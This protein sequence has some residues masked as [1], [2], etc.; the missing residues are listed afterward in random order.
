V[1]LV[2]SGV[3]V[4]AAQTEP[5]HSR[6][7]QQSELWLHGPAAAV[8][9]QVLDVGSQVRPAQQSEVVEQPSPLPAQLHVPVG[10]H[11]I[12]AQHWPSS[13]Q[14]WPIT[15]QAHVPALHRPEQQS[16]AALQALPFAVHVA[17]GSG[18][19][20][21]KHVS[22]V[23]SQSSS[24][25]QSSSVAQVLPMPAQAGV[26]RP[27]LQ[28][29]EQQS[30]PLVQALPLG[31]QPAA[32]PPSPPPPSSP[33]LPVTAVPHSPK[34]HASAQHSAYPAHEA[35]AG[36]HACEPEPHLPL[37]QA[38]AQHSLAL[39]Q[40]APSALQLAGGEPQVPALQLPPQ[41]SPAAWQLAPSWWHSELGAQTPAWQLPLQQS[42]GRVHA[43]AAAPHVGSAH[44]PVVHAPLQQ[45]AALAQAALAGRQLEGA[46]VP[47][48]LQVLLQQSL[49]ETHGCPFGAQ[50]L[51]AQTPAT[52]EPEQQSVYWVQVPPT[53]WQLS[54]DGPSAPS[55]CP[56]SAPPSVMVASVAASPPSPTSRGGRTK[57]A[58]LLPQA[59]SVETN[60]ATAIEAIAPRAHRWRDAGTYPCSV[61]PSRLRVFL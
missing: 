16:P 12:P 4:G 13:V 8:Q 25:Q 29:L 52:H 6:L 20:S 49:V 33:P 57:G 27:A 14:P 24:P 2:P 34:L 60:T 9:L 11:T 46:H 26:H 40:A 38:W 61:L 32:W 31:V 28:K 1:Q 54:E 30:P 58:L 39:V 48:A 47:S 5:T 45:S 37:V 53:A 43:A 55:P 35:P 44:A 56:A 36:L 21:T 51:P 18:T 10:S 42:D 15:A 19:T 22:M 50:R 41:Q 3:Q 59:P 23:S 7:P 17:P